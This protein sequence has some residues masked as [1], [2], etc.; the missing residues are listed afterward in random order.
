M[1]TFT[2]I[3]PNG[4]ISGMFQ[5]SLFFPG[6][7]QQS[8]K[9][10]NLVLFS[11]FPFAL[12]RIIQSIIFLRLYFLKEYTAELNSCPCRRVFLYF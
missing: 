8:F 2:N 9:K 7:F 6:M 10:F 4:K 3:I 1:L 12:I 11:R 5:Q